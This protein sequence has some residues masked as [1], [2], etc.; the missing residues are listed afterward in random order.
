MLLREEFQKAHQNKNLILNKKGKGMKRLVLCLLGVMLPLQATKG[1]KLIMEK[2]HEDKAREASALG[3]MKAAHTQQGY[4][5]MYGDYE[6]HMDHLGLR[7]CPPR[8]MYERFTHKF[9]ISAQGKMQRAHQRARRDV[10]NVLKALHHNAERHIVENAYKRALDSIDELALNIERYAQSRDWFTQ[11]DTSILDGKGLR[12]LAAEK[13]K[14]AHDAHEAR[15][16]AR[17]VVVNH[18]APV[19]TRK[20]DEDIDTQVY[21]HKGFFSKGFHGMCTES[22]TAGKMKRLAHD[23]KK[24][25]QRRDDVAHKRTK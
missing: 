16:N 13:R 20:D 15:E 9:R 11:D 7:V 12:R 23:Y 24:I 21:D 25:A 18:L 3:R 17:T 8:S 1:P 19:E 22:A 6:A 4:A 5:K 2:Y 10:N 14:K